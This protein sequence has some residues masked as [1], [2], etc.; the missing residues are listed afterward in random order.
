MSALANRYGFRLVTILGAV[1]GAAGFAISSL[2][3]SVT[4]L[5]LSFGL[6][7][8]VGFGMIYVPAVITTGFYFE[9][10]R[11]MATGIAVCGSG[12]GTFLM[13]PVCEAL[14]NSFGWK[15]MLLVQSG[16]WRRYSAPQRPQL[17]VIARE[18]R[19]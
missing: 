1:L 17:G 12:I 3:N 6:V 7:G 13:A 18:T 9:R 15:G 4:F 8:G 14:I 5:Y 11:A 2:A 19:A 16:E 10:W